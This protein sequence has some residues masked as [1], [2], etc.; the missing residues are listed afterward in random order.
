MLDVFRTLLY[1]LLK[2]GYT[3]LDFLANLI[4]KHL[5]EVD[6][7][8]IE[9]ELWRI[10]INTLI[11]W[12][13]NEILKKF[14]EQYKVKIEEILEI[15]DLYSYMSE[16]DLYEL[17]VDYFCSSINFYDTRLQNLFDN[18]EYWL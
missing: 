4:Y 13:L 7:E 2:C 3:D 14:F 9:W 8:E 12:V 11:Y 17:Y 16:N 5:I 15:D 18:S 10:D 1:Q 6:I